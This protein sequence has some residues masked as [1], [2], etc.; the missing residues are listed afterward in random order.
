M[1]ALNSLCAVLT[2]IL[3]IPILVLAALIVFVQSQ[4]RSVIDSRS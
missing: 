4:I 2:I 1:K 3:A